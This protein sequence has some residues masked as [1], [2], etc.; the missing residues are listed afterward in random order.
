MGLFSSAVAAQPKR[1]Q[2]EAETD[3]PQGCLAW[4]ERTRTALCSVLSSDGKEADGSAYSRNWWIFFVGPGASSYKRIQVAEDASSPEL[5]QPLAN[6]LREVIKQGNF[7][8]LGKPRLILRHGH[9]RE[10]TAE[11]V[12]L[13][14]TPSRIE[15]TQVT[16]RDGKQHNAAKVIRE[17]IDYRCAG[18]DFLPLWVEESRYKEAIAHPSAKIYTLGQYLL[19]EIN[20]DWSEGEDFGVQTFIRVLELQ[21][22]CGSVTKQ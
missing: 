15:K 17:R 2:V 9:Q 8:R 6:Q 7:L 13:R 5:T 3:L 1:L 10:L 16:G 14:W 22:H 20:W 18:S 12:T 21:P 4:S 11:G 19:A